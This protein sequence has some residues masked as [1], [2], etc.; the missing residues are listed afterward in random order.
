ML[1]VEPVAI[2]YEGIPE[3]VQLPAALTVVEPI[4]AVLSAYRFNVIG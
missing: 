2:S 4:S 3:T 1:N